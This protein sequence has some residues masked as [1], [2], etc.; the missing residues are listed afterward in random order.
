MLICQARNSGVT[1]CFS[2]LDLGFTYIS[3]LVIIK[4]FKFS[5]EYTLVVN[6]IMAPTLLCSAKLDL[7]ACILGFY[8]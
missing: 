8:I 4:L 5:S 7:T 6:P 3:V 1:A 2:S